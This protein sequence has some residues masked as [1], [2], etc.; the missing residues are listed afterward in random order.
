M[1]DLRVATRELLASPIVTAV[2][3]FSLALG[4]GAN[5]A[6]FSLVDSLL[7]RPLPIK[8]PHRLA[9]LSDT[10][11]APQGLT[12]AWTYAVWDQIR[13]RA[14][15]FDGACA[16][17]AE[18]LNL[19]P[20]GGETQPVDAVWVSGEYFTTL[21]VPALLGRTITAKDDVPGGGTD[22]A[23]AVIS[24]ELWQGR[25]GGA[26][27]AVGTPIVVERV[28]FT[29][30]GVAPPAFFGTDVGRTFDI[31]LPMNAEP[32]IRGAESRINLERG[33]SALSV[34]LRLKGGQ[35]F[36][37][38]TAILRRLQPQIRE[39]AMPAYM[40]AAVRKE[41]LKAA[42]TAAPGAT[43]ISRLRVR[44]ERPLVVILVVV[45]LVLL[46]A[47]AN[48]ANL[49]LARAIAR[50]HDTAVR[51]AL[52]AS[53]WRL[54]RQSFAESLLLAAAGTALGLLFAGWSSRLL[55]AQLSSVGNRVYLDLSF[56]W[57][58]LA[59]AVAIA[60]ATTIVFGVLP[61]VRASSV[62]PMDAVKEQARGATGSRARLS[63][64]LVVSQVALSVVIVVVAGLF[65]R[66]FA[67]LATL[68]LGFDADRVLLVNLN[69]ARTHVAPQDR[70]GFIGRIV[71][72][73]AGVPGAINVSASMI[74]PVQGLGMV[75]IVHVPGV[76]LSLQP[77][78]N[79]RLNNQSTFANFVTPGWFATYGTPIKAGRD[80]DD[81]D[82]KG[83][84][85]VIVVNEAFV[86]KFL[87]GQD[88]I[89]ATVAF[90]R[91]RSAPLPTT[92]IGVVGDAA[93]TSLRN[94]DVPIE[95]A[96]LAQFHFPGPPP[97]EFSISVRTSTG[98]PMLMARSIAA[99]LTSID[100]DLGFAFRPI[101]DQVRA[102]LIQER[103]IAN[104]SGFFGALALLL[105]GLGLYGTTAYVVSCRRAEFGIRMALGSSAAAVARLVVVRT[106]WLVAAGTLIG[107]VA[108]AWASSLVETLLYGVGPRDPKS[109]IGAGV[110]LLVVGMIAAWL[111]AHRASRLDPAAV[112]RE[113]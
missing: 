71:R 99:A 1:N 4:I 64:G 43:G 51:I 111:P 25:F 34:L 63:N 13:Q 20:H 27:N 52:G 22:G 61:A 66:S 58:I 90:E 46:I 94:G 14:Q 96:T 78:T 44:Y 101:A 62:P 42:F 28:P 112:L 19:A 89:G 55:V 49:Q 67:K 30:V 102:S 88:P 113:N 84:P 73:I 82:A 93:Y 107:V 87:H 17:F 76:P 108:S 56:D 8:E 3:I 59:F 24:Y 37:E 38:A 9:V 97:S 39:A 18:R 100:G 105:A 69:V 68:P 41:Y 47:C 32:L 21:G 77:M 65:V 109:L 40:P 80:F 16:W 83:A 45:A 57:R 6:I 95:Y 91:G 26:A 23:V 35:T 12:S 54:A 72:E 7:L 31:A 48:I 53:R 106:L 70:V 60:A 5:T 79:G 50:R 36:D 2:A 75:D 10:R 104:L 29:I 110:V 11:F 74:T 15:P 92:I 85:T 33:Y 86:R 103:L 81:R 98:A